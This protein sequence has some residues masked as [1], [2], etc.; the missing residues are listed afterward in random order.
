MSVFASA[1]DDLY[2]DPNLGVAAEYAPLAGS[3]Y[4]VRVMRSQPMAAFPALGTRA[5]LE[6]VRLTLRRSEV[7]NPVAGDRLTLS[8]IT[9]RIDGVEPD[10]EALEWRLAV[11]ELP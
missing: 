3:V 8:G 2:T 1:I 6:S 10:P 4:P 11:T 9:Y 5:V 7:G